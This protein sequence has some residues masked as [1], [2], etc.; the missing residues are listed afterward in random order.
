MDPNENDIWSWA[1]SIIMVSSSHYPQQG[2]AV[3][4]IGAVG[5]ARHWLHRILL[6]QDVPLHAATTARYMASM[7][8]PGTVL[9]T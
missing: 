2:D 8:S 5:D 1:G 7:A 9:G 4:G 3:P 6:G